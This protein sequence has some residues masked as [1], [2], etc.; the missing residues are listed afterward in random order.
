MELPGE[1]T[2]WEV[3]GKPHHH[4]FLCRACDGAYEVEGC[5]GDPRTVV[6][7]G[8]LLEAH[9]VVLYG[10]CGSCRDDAGTRAQG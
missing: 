10:V 6:P 9:E 1:A 7:E 4:H 3:A 2:R 8:F 5:P